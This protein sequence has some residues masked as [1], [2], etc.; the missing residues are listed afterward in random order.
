MPRLLHDQ[1]GMALPMVMGTLLLMLGIGALATQE[2]ISL[3]VSSNRDGNSKA[4]LATA[5]AGVQAARY[6]LAKVAPRDNM[7]VTTSAVL[8]DAN[9]NCPAVTEPHGNGA[10]YTY[11]TTPVLAA[12][13]TCA[14][15]FGAG[16]KQRCVTVSATA[17]GATRRVQVRVATTPSNLNP[18]N[19]IFG[20][21]KVEVGNNS[22]INAEVGS[23][24]TIKTGNGTKIGQAKLG[25]GGALTGNPKQTSPP[26]TN[27]SPFT[28]PPVAVAGTETANSNAAI[29]P[30]A[31][32]TAATRSLV[33]TSNIVLPSGDYNFCYLDFGSGGINAAP[34]ETVRIF[35]DAP[36]SVRP[37]SG[38]PTG[39][40][41][42]LL[43]GN[44]GVSLGQPNGAPAD[45]QVYVTGW[46][47][48]GS[49]ASTNGPNHI[50]VG[51]NNLDANAYIYAPNSLVDAGKN[52]AT[53]KGAVVG[54]EIYVKN[55]LTFAWDS[56][57]SFV[58]YGDYSRSGWRECRRQPSNPNDPESGCS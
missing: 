26:V 31:G 28:L 25:P 30:S 52:N 51:K 37:G 29:P 55:N 33:L 6:R 27:P 58:G 8:P 2:S 9:G 39:G 35:I 54:Q 22:D 47:S 44:N 43:D 5:Q 38:C 13:D 16:P 49:Y 46:P 18:V 53:I 50:T 11:H 17:H 19:G 3:S 45:L 34:G 41:W 23:N 20:L 32:Y 56:S 42:G 24:G 40:N 14:G 48:T 1:T 21:D 57:L 12:S 15:T 10:S 4:A 36:N 7:C